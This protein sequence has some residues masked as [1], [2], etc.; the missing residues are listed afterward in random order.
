[1]SHEVEANGLPPICASDEWSFLGGKW[2]EGQEGEMVT[3][4]TGAG[5]FLAPEHTS[6]GEFRAGNKFIVKICANCVAGDK[7]VNLK[8]AR[9]LAKPSAPTT[10]TFHPARIGSYSGQRL[11]ASRGSSGVPTAAFA[12][13]T[14]DVLSR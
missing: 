14:N 2:H 7:S 5:P 13:A 6:I 10:W 9:D 4:G 3:P 8:R 11:S 1:M 12:N